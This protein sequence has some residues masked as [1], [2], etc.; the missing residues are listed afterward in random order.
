MFCMDFWKNLPRLLP[1]RDHGSSGNRRKQQSG[2]RSQPAASPAP[3]TEQAISGGPVK[4][5]QQPDGNYVLVHPRCVSERE[6]D[7]EDVE[8]MLDSGEVD[9]ARDELRY[10]LNGCTD[11]LQ[12]HFM[13]GELALAENDVAL[14]RGHYGY[15]FQIGEKALG[16]ANCPGPVP[17]DLP[18][19]E[20][21]H[22]A[23]KQLAW[24]LKLLDK[25]E[26]MRTVIETLVK[27]DARDLL[28]L[29]AL[30]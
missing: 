10:L 26:L 18:A 24:C 19:N 6:M 5:R 25:P 13:L 12:I 22:H 15:A 17:A 28:Q 2:K 21:W 29:Q 9:V 11:H 23:G 4:V 27:Y 16:K 30:L 3:S 1:D 14:A 20:L 8:A 7:L